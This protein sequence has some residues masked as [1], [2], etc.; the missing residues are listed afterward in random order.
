[1]DEQRR[2][3]LDR[4]TDPDGTP[5]FVNMVTGQTGWTCLEAQTVPIQ[6]S[7]IGHVVEA[8]LQCDAD[9]MDYVSLVP[10]Q[11]MH[12]LQCYLQVLLAYDCP[13]F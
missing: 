8:L 4:R 7:S 6:F 10:Q 12:P 13:S 11:L 2:G 5:Y 9:V 3:E 1:M